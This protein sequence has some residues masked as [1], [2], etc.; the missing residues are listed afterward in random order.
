MLELFRGHGHHRQARLFHQFHLA[1]DFVG[2]NYY[3]TVYFKGIS[4][5]NPSRYNR[6]HTG[7]R[8]PHKRNRRNPPGPRSDLGWY[9]EPESLYKEIM[10]VARRYKKP[11]LITETGVADAKDQYR[12]WWLEQTLEAIAKANDNHAHV[13]GYFVWS[14]LDNFEWA[15]GW[16]P[17][18]GLVEV[19][20]ENGMKRKVRPSAEWLAKYINGH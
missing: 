19:D 5:K 12:Q 1:Q 15:Q 14:L 8:G 9:M 20:R 6:H 16:W 3:F 13:I 7:Q 17:K 18:F 4:R 10:A 2:F 11:I